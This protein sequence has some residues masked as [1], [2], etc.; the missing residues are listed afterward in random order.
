M[1]RIKD[2]FAQKVGP[3]SS[4][5]WCPVVEGVHS[6]Q[7]ESKSDV[8]YEN[9]RRTPSLDA[10]RPPCLL[11]F[12]EPACSSHQPQARSLRISLTQPWEKSGKALTLNLECILK[13]KKGL[14]SCAFWGP[15]PM[16]MFYLLGLSC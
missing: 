15:D 7:F 13:T 12:W 16:G 6:L 2:K 11:K 1:V 3:S 10:P 9:V 4:K 8:I 5:V 14:G